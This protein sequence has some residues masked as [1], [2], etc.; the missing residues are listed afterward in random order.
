MARLLAGAAADE[1]YLEPAQVKGWGKFG[2]TGVDHCAA[3]TLQFE[4]DII[5]EIITGVGCG[6]PS[7]VSVYGSGGMLSIPN[8]WLPASPCRSAGEPLPLDTVFPA[9]TIVLQTH[10]SRDPEE[11]LVEVD[12]DLFTCEADTLAENIPNR[13]GRAMSWQDTLG[14]MRLL[15]RWRAE[16]GI[17]YEK[18][19]TNR[20]LGSM[21]EKET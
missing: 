17:V 7:D 10:R 6:I 19:K 15:D 20:I 18:E 11:I 1:P 12:R 16:V 3:A 5:A 14:N 2:P 13:Q 9:T 21:S 4:N 8:P